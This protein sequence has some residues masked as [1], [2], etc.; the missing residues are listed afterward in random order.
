[1]QRVKQTP[2]AKLKSRQ[3]PKEPLSTFREMVRYSYH[4]KLPYIVL[5]SLANAKALPSDETVLNEL[6]VFARRDESIPE[7]NPAIW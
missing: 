2:C 1:M 4:I 7:Q 6:K 3:L 5:R